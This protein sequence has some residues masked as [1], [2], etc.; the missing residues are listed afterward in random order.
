[1]LSWPSLLIFS[2]RFTHIVVTHHLKVERTTGSVRRPKNGVLHDDDDDDDDDDHCML[3]FEAVW[4]WILRT[5]DGSAWQL[6]P[7][8]TQESSWYA[9]PRGRSARQAATLRQGLRLCGHRGRQ[10]RR[11]A[12]PPC[13]RLDQTRSTSSQSEIVVTE[14]F[15]GINDAE[16]SFVIFV[17][18]PVLGRWASFFIGFNIFCQCCSC[19]SI[20]VVVWFSEFCP[21]KLKILCA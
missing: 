5:C 21:R 9:S 18:H 17:S 1:M 7:A 14:I 16:V 13:R 3:G 15:T 2:R 4:V 19:Y 20:Q 6:Q 10:H 11:T 8:R 12:K